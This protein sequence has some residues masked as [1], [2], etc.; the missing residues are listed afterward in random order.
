M[1]E[2]FQVAAFAVTLAI[3]VLFGRAIFELIRMFA[4]SWR[5]SGLALVAANLVYG[6]TDAPLRAVGRVIKPIRLGGVSLDLAFLAILLALMFLQ[7]VL[8]GRARI[9]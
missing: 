4:R 1:S 8:F 5:P 6:I 3:V 9:M 7:R 2:L